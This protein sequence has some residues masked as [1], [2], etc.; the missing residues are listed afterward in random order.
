MLVGPY[1]INPHVTFI[2]CIN[3]G[4]WL[5]NLLITYLFTIIVKLKFI[6]ICYSTNIFNMLHTKKHLTQGFYNHQ[7]WLDFTKNVSF[8]CQNVNSKKLQ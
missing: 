8:V 4:N 3:L 7:S 5:L 2:M 6:T 1:N